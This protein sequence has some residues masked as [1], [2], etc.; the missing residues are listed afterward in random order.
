[1]INTVPINWNIAGTGDFNGDRKVDILWRNNSGADAIWF[2]SG[3]MTLA[4]SLIRNSRKTLC[5]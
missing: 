2:M 3:A 4:A 5:L 1:V